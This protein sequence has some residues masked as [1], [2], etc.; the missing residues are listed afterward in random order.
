MDCCGVARHAGEG[1]SH[2]GWDNHGVGIRKC[3]GHGGNRLSVVCDSDPALRHKQVDADLAAGVPVG[4]KAGQKNTFMQAGKGRQSLRYGDKVQVVQFVASHDALIQS[5]S[6][7]YTS[8][9]QLR[10]VHSECGDGRAGATGAGA[11]ANDVGYGRI[12]AGI[13]VRAGTVDVS[14]CQIGS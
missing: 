5:Y 2:A 6:R 12:I 4:R 14:C 11:A 1:N 3:G 8:T 7:C 10:D 9:I 13:S